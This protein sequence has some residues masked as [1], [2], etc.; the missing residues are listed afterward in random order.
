MDHL[1]QQFAMIANATILGA[2][3]FSP[4]GIAI[5]ADGNIYTANFG[6]SNVLRI[7]PDGTS[8]IFGTTGDLPQIL[9]RDAGIRK[10]R[11]A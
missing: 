10:L 2:T 7:P 1:G 5:D 4:I 6:S 3:G 11:K 9:A 8:T